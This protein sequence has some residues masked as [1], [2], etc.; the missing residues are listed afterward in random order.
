MLA[1]QRSSAPV[2]EGV[3]RGFQKKIFARA[4][5]Q[6]ITCRNSFDW[7]S[8]MQGWPAVHSMGTR[9]TQW[10]R[11][12]FQIMSDTADLFPVKCFVQPRLSPLQELALS[13]IEENLGGKVWRERSRGASEAQNLKPTDAK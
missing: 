1:M 3:I 9:Q 12:C 13:L 7:F 11:T 8:A 2:E 10:A 4:V 5:F 6:T